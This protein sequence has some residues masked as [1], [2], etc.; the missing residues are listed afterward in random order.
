MPEKEKNPGFVV[1]DRRK[2]TLEGEPASPAQQHKEEPPTPPAPAQPQQ[3]AAPEPPLP[4][5]KP[6][7]DEQ[8][9][10]SQEA[11][12]EADRQLDSQLSDIGQAEQFRMNFEMFLWNL[13]VSGLVQLG[14]VP[15]EGKDP[16]ERMVDPVAARHTIDTLSILEEK[17]KGNLTDKEKELM[18]RFLFELRMAFLD[19]MNALAR[20]AKSP[21]AGS[22]L[23]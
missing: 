5:L 20:Q 11:Y 12:R 13:Y 17:T 23:K 10:N 2:F 19:V 3:S 6:P 22:E 8:I 21:G 4:E 16:K 1:T 9:S 15:Q 14:A 7:T 18:Q